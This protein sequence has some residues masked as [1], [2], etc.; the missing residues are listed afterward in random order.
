MLRVLVIVFSN[1]YWPKPAAPRVVLTV[2]RLRL[3]RYEI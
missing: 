2:R 3:F 1:G